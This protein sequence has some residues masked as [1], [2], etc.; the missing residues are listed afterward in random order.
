MEVQVFDHLRVTSEEGDVELGGSKQQT[1]L[2][3]LIL[4]NGAV[5]SSERLIEIVWRNRPPA[6]PEVTLRSYISH[7]R[8]SLEPAQ[9][10]GDRAQVLI[11]RAPGYAIDTDRL[12]VDI[13]RFAE[14]GRRALA[15]NGDTPA[16]AIFEATEQAL[17][18]WPQRGA[19]SIDTATQSLAEFPEEVA[20]LTELH[21]ALTVRHLR[22]A[23]EDGRAES[24]LPSL[25]IASG[26]HPTSEELVALHM[27][28][29]FRC[30]RSSDALA[31]FQQARRALRD[32]FGLDPSPLL[33]ALE[34]RILSND[35]SLLGPTP[36]SASA[37]GSG[38]PEAPAG[39]GDALEQILP[40]L[41]R[42]GTGVCGA[43]IVGPAGIGKSTVLS[44]VAD[45]ALHRGIDVVWGR[46]TD[47]VS[48]ATL[49]PW[50][51]VLRDLLERTD[52]AVCDEVFAPQAADLRRVVPELATRFPT[53]DGPVIDGDISDAIVR[54]LQRWSAQR[55]L[56]VCLEDLHWSD[57]ESL[58]VL[59]HLLASAA[60]SPLSVI[61]TWRDTDIAAEAAQSPATRPRLLADVARAVGDRRVRL[62][63]LG[64]SDLNDMYR[65][66]RGGELPSADIRRLAE[67]TGGNPLFATE[68]IRAGIDGDLAPTDTIREVVLRRLDPL[69]TQA[70]AIL[71]AAALCHPSVDESM[72]SDISG[73]HDDTLSECLEAALAA[74]LIEDN[75]R[76]FG[77]YRFTHDLLAETLAG[78]LPRRRRSEL[79]ARIGRLLEQRRAPSAE[80]A[81]HYLRGRT[82]GCW[83]SAARFAHVAGNEAAALAD[84]H[85][86]L[87]LFDAAIESLDGGPDAPQ[88]RIDIGIDRAQV[89]KFLSRHVESQHAS[90]DAFELARENGELELM[91][92]AAMV[93]IGRSRLDRTE[94]SVE[95]LGY[96][97]P[98]DESVFVLER[99]LE[100]MA[101]EHPWR[102]L[103]VLALSNQLFAPH[104][105]QERADRLARSGIALLRHQ[106]DPEAL[107]E[108][109]VSM[110]TAHCRTL[111]ADERESLLLDA[112]VFAGRAGQRR[113]ELRA[114]KALM[115]VA[116][117]RRDLGL[118]REQVE[119][120][121]AMAAR[122]DDP[123]LTMQAESMRISLDLLTGEFD[124]ARARV[125]DGLTAFAK[126]GD[127][128]TDTFGMQYFT[129]ARAAAEFQPIIGAIED[130]LSGYDG[131]AYGA[132]LAA[133]LA[134]AGDL[135]RAR[136]VID[137][138]SP[139]DIAWGGEGVLQ[140]MTPAFF[141]DAIADLAPTHPDLL[142]LAPALLEALSPAKDRLVT[143]VGGADYPSLGSYYSARLLTHLE[144]TAEADGLLDRTIEHLTDIE[145]RPALLWARL[146]RAENLAVAGDRIGAD[147]VLSSAADDAERLDMAW[148]IDW[149]RR[150]LEQVS[151]SGP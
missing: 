87:R 10:A 88:Q 86:A 118:A 135:D 25:E 23:L 94:R 40:C 138:F 92:V 35:P 150:R 43:A 56:L 130:K 72:L 104:H 38:P 54:T 120:A 31:R 85:G 103:V 61:A 50:Q 133:V 108:G 117:D 59:D 58:V 119:L 115:S 116:L 147:G 143:I 47:A 5:V 11:T 41:P 62:E 93:Y 107:S 84:Y 21:L 46:C 90:M 111:P 145:A 128:V 51:S 60:T 14:D 131:P 121:G 77:H 122:V 106:N 18:H 22:A 69:P 89:L 20:R 129:L 7:L 109:L 125:F 75:P 137:R 30:G 71:A 49:R 27:T 149:Q 97:S 105:D 101:D 124:R 100:L 132:P 78:T 34:Q 68:L 63:G 74:R 81:H 3:S 141:A 33:I 144:A 44:A 65:N 76:R 82:A 134:R 28:A 98:P 57:D 148:A 96:W 24:A 52:P 95:W 70:G 6:K 32:D 127:A 110:A 64:E 142:D 48:T 139:V 91:I 29:L 36:S 55:P 102:P 39:R 26:Q 9:R 67:H 151:P 53:D 114:R 99:S 42:P 80:I 140:F 4:A 83:L 79:H 123:F 12:A 13:H 73:H 15:L 136:S 2:L 19:A 66:L 16:Q 8:R 17:A 126:F 45:H 146:A 112:L 113:T 1:V 37:V